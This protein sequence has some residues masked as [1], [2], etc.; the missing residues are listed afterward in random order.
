LAEK[1]IYKIYNQRKQ[2]KFHLILANIGD[3]S[4]H[5]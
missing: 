4:A 3:N 1:Y 5:F 2:D